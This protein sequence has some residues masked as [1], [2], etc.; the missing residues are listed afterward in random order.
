MKIYNLAFFYSYLILFFLSQKSYGETFLKVVVE[1]FTKVE[2]VSA[3]VTIVNGK[4][5]T[6]NCDDLS[7]KSTDQIKYSLQLVDSVYLC[8]PDKEEL[9]IFNDVNLDLGFELN[10]KNIKTQIEA[11]SRQFEIDQNITKG[12]L[13]SASVQNPSCSILSDGTIDFESCTC[14]SDY[15]FD[16]VSKSCIKNQADLA[17][18]MDNCSDQYHNIKK[19]LDVIGESLIPEPSV[20]MLI[21]GTDTLVYS[22]ASHLLVYKILLFAYL[23]E[24][25]VSTLSAQMDVEDVKLY[26]SKAELADYMAWANAT[27]GTET[28]SLDRIIMSFT[29]NFASHRGLSKFVEFEE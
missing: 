5:I 6:S 7:K 25:I 20:T 13:F 17:F 11:A 15:K 14:P 1:S 21:C 12:S 26:I 19:V 22:V 16:K 8:V 9:S 18:Y 27:H 29:N 24:H 4:V 23:K 3:E 10:I 2:S 28:T